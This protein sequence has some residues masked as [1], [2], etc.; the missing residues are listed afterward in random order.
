[1][2]GASKEHLLSEVALKAAALQRRPGQLLDSL[3]AEALVW[4]QQLTESVAAMPG[5]G[6]QDLAEVPH[7][8][9]DNGLQQVVGG[10]RDVLTAAEGKCCLGMTRAEEGRTVADAA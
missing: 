4:W 1:M 2:P 7:P 5:I 10:F 3:Q 9:A 6:D 8:V